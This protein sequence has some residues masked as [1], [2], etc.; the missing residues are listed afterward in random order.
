MRKRIALAL[1]SGAA[2]GLAHIGVL[3][4]F[5]ENSIPVHIVAGSSMGAFIGALYAAGLSVEQIEE[6]A[7]NVD[8]KL[9]AKMM[10]PSLKRSG[11]VAGERIKNL[12]NTIVGNLNIDDCKIPFAAVATD[13]MSGEEI[14]IRHGSLTEAVRASI[15]IPAIFT[16]VRYKNGFLV[17]GGLVNPVPVSVAKN[18]GADIVIAVNVTPSIYQKVENI[19]I[20]NE[21][22]DKNEMLAT[23]SKMLN[24]LIGRYV[25][26]KVDKFTSGIKNMIDI[27]KNQQGKKSPA[28][29]IVT[30]ILQTI[31]IM[32]NEILQLK[33]EQTPP[34]V[35]IDPIIDTIS[36]LDFHKAKEIIH[37]GEEA[38]NDA[39]PIIRKKL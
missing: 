20:E 6:I 5:H 25:Q 27:D 36:L 31:H 28:P 2:R 35:L 9:T 11:L 4:V 12:I 17:D 8:L 26:Q 10:M 37:A 14:V 39:L 7:C 19:T 13:L 1:G 33:I 24:L 30:T 32:E 34:D 16:P 29:N 38:A 21:K 15:S 3:K 23:S 18:M 22:N